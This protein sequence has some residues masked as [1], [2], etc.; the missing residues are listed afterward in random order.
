MLPNDVLSPLF[1]A[2]VEATEEAIVN[3]LVAAKTM[4]G[5]NG[6]TAHALPHDRLQ[7]ALK[8]YGRLR[9]AGRVALSAEPRDDR[10]HRRHHPLDLR[11]VLLPLVRVGLRLRV[12]DSGSG[13]DRYSSSRGSIARPA[14]SSSFAISARGSRTNSS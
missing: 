3:A 14:N 5:A 13:F 2:T 8:K 6:Y 9:D 12:P 11:R 7:A 1:D 4:T 10:G